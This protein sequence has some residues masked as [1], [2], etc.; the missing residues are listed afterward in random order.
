MYSFSVG[1]SFFDDCFGCCKGEIFRLGMEFC[2]GNYV[3]DGTGEKK[4]R[5]AS[6]NQ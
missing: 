1:F 6:T 3:K 5:N 2:A 4:F